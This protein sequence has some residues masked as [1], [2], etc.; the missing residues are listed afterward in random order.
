MP[1]RQTNLGLFTMPASPKVRILVAEDD[2]ISRQIIQNLLSGWGYEVETADDGQKAMM[3]LRS[4]H[5]P[6]IAILDWE[7]P[8]MDGLEIC[9]R[10]READ[11]TVYLLM[12][13]GREGKENM[14]KALESGA[15][16]Y[17]SKPCDPDE[18]QVRIRVGERI[19][20]LQRALADQVRELQFAK[21]RLDFIERRGL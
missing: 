18:L 15:D 9:R 8:G 5:S 1:S 6:T 2:H 4:V 19:I 7:M 16:D 13:T 21:E 3:A 17:L 11:R 12:L 20:G 10:V 14:I